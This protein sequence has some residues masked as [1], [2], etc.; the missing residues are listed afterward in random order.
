MTAAITIH[1]KK[2]ELTSSCVDSLLADGWAPI[3]IWDNSDDEGASLKVLQDRYAAEPRVRLVRSPINLGFGKGMNAALAALGRQSYSGPVLLMNN[4]AKVMPGMRMALEAQLSDDVV[5][6]LVAPRLMQGGHEQ[7]WLYYQPWLALVTRRPLPGS[8]V[9]LSGCCLLVHRSDNAQPL[10]DED[11]FM[12]G[13][14]VELSWRMRRQG[15]RLLLLDRSHV[16]H[17]GSA[18][19]GQASETYERFLVQSHWLLAQ[20]LGSNTGS[21]M[22][23]R[24]LRLPSLFARA[25]LRSWRYRSLVPLRAA[26]SILNRSFC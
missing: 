5:P 1:F 13:E 3:L 18:S 15:A 10:F 7:G 4:D 19:S 11:F 16:C 20:K 23:M 17:E 26:L 2:P 8:F 6:T 25:C 21:R 12:Y 24:A 14:D 9:Y 22:L